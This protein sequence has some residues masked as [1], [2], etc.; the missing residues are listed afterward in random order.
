MS[1]LSGIQAAYS[2]YRLFSLGEPSTRLQ[3]L[4]HFTPDQLFFLSFAQVRVF[5]PKFAF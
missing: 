3:D 4:A 2:A 5:W 1:D